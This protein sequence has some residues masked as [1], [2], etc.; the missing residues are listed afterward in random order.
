MRILKYVLSPGAGVI[1]THEGAK[2]I[3]A[4]V[5]DGV[6]VLWA[7]VDP[8]MPSGQLETRVYETGDYILDN[9]QFL[10]TIVREVY[11]YHV[12]TS[13]VAV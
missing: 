3:S 10:S 2:P 6:L 8:A 7:L 5:Q 1:Y 11:V 12:F 13:G 4:Q 9:L